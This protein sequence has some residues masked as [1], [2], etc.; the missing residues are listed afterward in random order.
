MTATDS[1]PGGWRLW[2][3]RVW[4]RIRGWAKVTVSAATHSVYSVAT[5]IK[6][7]ADDA[8]RI[9]ADRVA[10]D[11]GYV[12][13][14]TEAVSGIATVLIPRMRW[15]VSMTVLVI[16]AVTAPTRPR[17]TPSTR[18]N[19]SED[20]PHPPEPTRGGYQVPPLS[21]WDRFLTE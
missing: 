16:D 1:N 4:S 6:V 8:R 7:I 14:L 13:N 19:D 3:R 12:R 10:T 11:F 2:L 20:P 15:W 5:R 18:V 9:H 17:H 21:A